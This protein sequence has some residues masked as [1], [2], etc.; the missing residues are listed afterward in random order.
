MKR[1]NLIPKQ[2]KKDQSLFAPAA[3][4]KKWKF[5]RVTVIVMILAV[6]VLLPGIISKRHEGN[7]LKAKQQVEAMKQER[8][9]L[10]SRRQQIGKD[11]DLLMKKKA[12]ADGRLQYLK[13]AETSKPGELSQSLVYLP[14]LIPDEIWINKLT[15]NRDG[16]II[17][18]STLN[19]QAVSKF[20]DNLNK[21]N[22]FK[23]SSF[24]FT[25]K[26][27]IG[28][29]TLYNFEIATNLVK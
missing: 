10:L 13:E 4:L 8:N 19:N 22:K 11:Y 15:I 17:N 14:T 18:G 21:S 29:A 2:G 25:Q 27:E 24:N 7:L 3:V 12:A 6:A 9:R 20:I 16:V 23:G 28:Q 1:L 5:N 26:S